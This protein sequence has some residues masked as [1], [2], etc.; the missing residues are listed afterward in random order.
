M[1][2]S[3]KQEF[4]RKLIHLSSFWIVGLIWFCPRT[5]AILLISVV[6]VFVL[7]TEY[8]MHKNPFCAR[9][10]HLLFSP[11]LREKES[12]ATFGFSGAP[13][14]LLAALILVIVMP[15]DVAMFGVSVLLLSDTMAAIVGRAFG[16]H[17]LCGKKTWEGAL[18]FLSSGFLVCFIFDVCFGLPIYLGFVGVCL[19]CLGDLLND[20][21]HI[22]DNFSIPLLAVL[23]F[24]F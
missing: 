22:D 1:A 20:Y 19:G 17:P 12:Q 16:R 10:Y 18:A 3:F 23:P 15:K 9:V 4:L 21:I 2:F 11:V 14:V 5:I 6:T 8:E 24:L 13:Y 7:L